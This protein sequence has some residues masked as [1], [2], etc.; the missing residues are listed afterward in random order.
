MI[1]AKETLDIF[2]PIAH[3]IGMG[4]IKT[5]LEDISFKYIHNKEYEEIKNY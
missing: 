3:R 1:K 5:E 2:V 4:K